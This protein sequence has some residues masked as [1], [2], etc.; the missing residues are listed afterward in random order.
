[1]KFQVVTLKSSRG[2]SKVRFRPYATTHTIIFTA[3]GV[4]GRL[5]AQ[6][7]RRHRTFFNIAL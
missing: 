5:R 1:M 6:R 7:G 2:H 3:V 4:R